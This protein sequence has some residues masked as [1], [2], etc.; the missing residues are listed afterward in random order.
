MLKT[1]LFISHLE[2]YANLVVKGH[3]LF[4]YIAIKDNFTLLDG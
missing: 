1:Y 2:F 4:D 3:T